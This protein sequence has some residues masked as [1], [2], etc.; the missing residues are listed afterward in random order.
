MQCGLI[1]HDLSASRRDTDNSDN[2]YMQDGFPPVPSKI[3]ILPGGTRMY[4]VGS[5]GAC[6]VFLGNSPTSTFAGEIKTL[7]VKTNSEKRHQ[8]EGKACFYKVM[9]H[10]FQRCACPQQA[11]D[12]ASPTSIEMI[13]HASPES[14][15]WLARLRDG[16]VESTEG[17]IVFKCNDSAKG[18]LYARWYLQGTYLYGHD[19]NIYVYE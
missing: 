8:G 9:D 18:A 5:E 1:D 13:V 7:D 16:Y 3:E 12:F 4:T 2:W 15:K 6:V 10:V 19:M 11:R 14:R 17:E